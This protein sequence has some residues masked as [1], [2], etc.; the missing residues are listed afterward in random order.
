MYR[1][2][3]LFRGSDATDA[4]RIRCLIRQLG[5]VEKAGHEEV[6]KQIRLQIANFFI[7]RTARLTF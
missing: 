4:V 2:E 6:A 7:N 1:S 3:S 5:E